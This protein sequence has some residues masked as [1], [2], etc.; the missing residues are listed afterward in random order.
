[1]QFAARITGYFDRW[2]E[3]AEAGNDFYQL[4]DR[5]IAEQFLRTCSNRFA[6]FFKEKSCVTLES[7]AKNDDLYLEAQSHGSNDK[8][9]SHNIV[10]YVAEKKSEA[11]KRLSTRGSIRCFL[12][13]KVGHKAADC[14]RGVTSSSSS[15]MCRIC[16][17]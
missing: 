10:T 3:K 13:N 4:K 8:V 11:H 1:M 7:L 6:V 9:K 12:C 2:K 5:I 17:K 15:G 14:F 16:G